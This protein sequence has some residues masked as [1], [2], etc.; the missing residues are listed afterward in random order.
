MVRLYGYELHAHINDSHESPTGVYHATDI[1][2]T[3]HVVNLLDCIGEDD[4]DNLIVHDSFDLGIKIGDE[5]EFNN[6][7]YMSI[8]HGDIFIL[9]YGEY[10][11]GDSII[12]HGWYWKM[13]TKINSDYLLG[14]SINTS[15]E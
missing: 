1:N 11:S 4:Y 6:N 15:K 10:K 5:W 13:M 9:K 14:I 7:K 3:E 8:G 12:S 2:I